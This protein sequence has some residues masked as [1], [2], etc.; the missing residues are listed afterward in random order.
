[1][2]KL[3]D[4]DVREPVKCVMLGSVFKFPGGHDMGDTLGM[5]S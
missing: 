4:N 3:K 2:Y 1:M 5:G